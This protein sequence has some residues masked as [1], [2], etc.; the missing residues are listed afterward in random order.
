MIKVIKFTGRS[1]LSQSDDTKNFVRNI[2]KSML[3]QSMS[4]KYF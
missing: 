2:V 1:T 3:Y 4:I